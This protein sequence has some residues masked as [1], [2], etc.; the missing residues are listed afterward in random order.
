MTEYCFVVDKNNNKLSPTNINKGWY[1]IRKGRAKLT[2]KYPMTI[3]LS[4]EVSDKEKD[5]SEF[6]V[7]IDDGSKFVGLAI[8]QICKAKVKIV[9]KSTILLRKDVKHLMDVRRGYRRYHRYHKHYRPKRFNNR[10]SSKREGRIPPSIRQKKDSILRVVR[11]LNKIVTI[12]QIIL[13][14]V[15]IDIRA[16]TEG[17]KPYVWQ[18]TKS[19]RLDENLRIATLIRDKFTCQKCGKTACGLEA[20]HIIPKRKGGNDSIRNLISLCNGCHDNIKYHELDYVSF[21]QTLIQGRNVN[22]KDAQHVMQGKTYLRQEL[23]KVA[24]VNLTNGGDTANKRIDWDIPKSHSNDA[25]V[26]CNR[27]ITA[28]QCNI[29]EWT[30]KPM[31]SKSKRKI[32]F[33]SGFKHRDLVRYTKKDGQSYTGYI[34]AIYPA[35]KCVNIIT[36]DGK[37][38]NRYGINRLNLIWRFS[39]IYWFNINRKEGLAA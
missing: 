12:N 23:E 7:G 19:N 32:E 26:I 11:Q 1:L 14:D 10:K 27:K 16:L 3:Q 5:A 13:E 2:N 22:F 34:T 37:I 6:V 38:L 20:H 30:V 28:T 35:R 39:K 25:V 8:I 4:K 15:A 21:F 31:R 33:L 29:A 17:Y 18:Y 24:P 36:L 9:F